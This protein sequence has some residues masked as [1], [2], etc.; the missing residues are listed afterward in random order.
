MIRHYCIVIALSFAV[1]CSGQHSSVSEIDTAVLKAA[2]LQNDIQL[3]DVR[4]PEEFAKGH[5]SGAKNIGI[6]NVNQFKKEV[7]ILEKTKPVYLYCQAGVRSGRATTL[8]VELGFTKI[9][10]YSP[11]YRV[12][13][14]ER[15]T[16]N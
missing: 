8:L 15:N 14:K 16:K 9:F 6:A 1:A 2:I 13:K 11:G 5:I 10:D 4:T 3:I 7:Q 12:W